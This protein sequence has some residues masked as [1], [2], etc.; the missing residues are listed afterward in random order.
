MK[1]EI[2]VNKSILKIPCLKRWQSKNRKIA[3][4]QNAESGETNP[5]RRYWPACWHSE[6]E[7]PEKGNKAE[8]CARALPSPDLIHLYKSMIFNR[9]S[10]SSAKSY[11]Y[12]VRGGIHLL[13]NM[14]K[15]QKHLY[16]NYESKTRSENFCW[17]LLDIESWFFFYI[18]GL[19]SWFSF[20]FEAVEVEKC[21][22]RA[23]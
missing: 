22:R 18:G 5:I 7:L 15:A 12:K 4:Y 1:I 17:F 20:Y 21:S 14:H 9:I 13:Q 19:T 2:A 11:I 8:I 23:I 16:L 6:P 10:L 3:K